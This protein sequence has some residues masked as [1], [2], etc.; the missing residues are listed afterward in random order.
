VVDSSGK[1]QS[2]TRPLWIVQD[3]PPVALSPRENEVVAAFLGRKVPFA[4]S[5]VVGI[6]T[7]EL[8]VSDAPEFGNVLFQRR[9]DATSLRTDVDLPE[10]KYYWRVRAS[11]AERGESP[12]AGARSFRLLRKPLP[13]TPEL[14]DPELEVEL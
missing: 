3:V 8:Q 5:H 10:G 2:E 11:S 14:L 9:V 1:P 4:W 7:Y 13:G 12:W 6:R